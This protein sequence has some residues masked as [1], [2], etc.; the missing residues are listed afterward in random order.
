MLNQGNGVEYLSAK[1]G[2][3]GKIHGNCLRRRCQWY[4]WNNL[5]GKEFYVQ[6]AE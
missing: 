6:E 1:N 3:K 5:R 4:V 2:L